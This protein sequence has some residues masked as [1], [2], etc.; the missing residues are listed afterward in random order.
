VQLRRQ[1][2]VHRRQRPPRANPDRTARD[3]QVDAVA[4]LAA[5]F[6]LAAGMVSVPVAEIARA[7]RQLDWEVK[8]V[9]V[10]RQRPSV[11]AT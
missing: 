2:G 6:D 3:R 1:V 10:L 9:A 4:K 7:G 8:R 5:A 11:G